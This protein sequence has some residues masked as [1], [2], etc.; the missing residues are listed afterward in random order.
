MTSL[1]RSRGNKSP[2]F[3]SVSHFPFSKGL[4]KIGRV[5]NF[6]RSQ[7]FLLLLAVALAVGFAAPLQ[8]LK[9]ESLPGMRSGLVAVVLFIMGLTVP[10]S[11][12]GA[13]IRRPTAGLLALGIN[14][15]VV[16]GLAF[17]ASRFM[18]EALGG[19][20]IVAAA[21]PCTLASAVVWTRKG[22]GDEAVAM[23]VTV[24]TNLF[25]FLIAPAT[26]L[27][28]LGADVEMSFGNQAGKLA[29]LVV[30]PLLLAQ[31]ARQQPAFGRWTQR[32]KKSLTNASL[33]GI[34]TMVSMGAAHS[35]QQS[36]ATESAGGMGWN[37]I[38]ATAVIAVI[39]HVAALAVGW[40]LANVAAVSSP[41]RTAVAIAGSQ[42]TLMVGL[43]LAIECG[44]SPIPMVVYH[45]G[46]LLFDTLFVSRIG[47]PLAG[48][49][50][51]H[52]RHDHQPVQ[53]DAKGSQDNP[54]PCVH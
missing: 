4:K 6:V 27:L 9:L 5:K 40:W 2:R 52:H 26:I 29:M 1:A 24:L 35:H 15:L 33:L 31:I 16:P 34:L 10:T 45:I 17:I 37:W 48:D 51:H 39:V 50:S 12:F 18:P 13:V 47:L 22:G 23:L 21:A 54:D 32:H 20:L 25:C 19:G 42:K 41:Q 7:W 8:V 53:H 11:S 14:V 38:L 3:S 44:V 36:S 46:Q 43:Q 49:Q 30:T 28:L